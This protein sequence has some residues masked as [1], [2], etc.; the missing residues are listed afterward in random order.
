MGRIKIGQITNAVGIKGELRVY[1]YLE[2]AGH[3]SEIRELY[4]EDRLCRITGVRFVKN[5]VVLRL[6][7]IATRSDAEAL[8]GKNLY[9]DRDKL[10]KMDDDS[11]LTDDLIGM[12]VELAD[13]TVV[14]TLVRVLP[15]PAH[16]LY[17]IRTEDQRTFLLPAVGEFILKVLPQEKRMIVKLIEGLVDL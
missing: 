2:E 17:E 9:V 8:K 3:F 5:M 11:Y 13:G 14:G 10:W 6:S 7:D 12:S 4:V 15:N 16:S 1:P